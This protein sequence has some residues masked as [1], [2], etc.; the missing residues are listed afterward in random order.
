[1]NL[2]IELHFFSLVLTLTENA[3]VFAE[4]DKDVL[5]ELIFATKKKLVS[6]FVQKDIS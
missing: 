6:C 3:F 5:I 4:L 2:E 1:M